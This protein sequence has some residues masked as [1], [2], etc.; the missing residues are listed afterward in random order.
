MTTTTDT[1]GAEFTL[2]GPY[3]TIAAI[4]EANRKAGH[5]F[6]EADS[7]RFFRSKIARGVIIAGRLFITSEQFVPSDGPPDP[8][9]YSVRVAH[10]NGSVATVGEFQA[11]ATL[12]EA[13]RAAKE[14]AR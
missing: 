3:T 8:R 11:Y 5:H 9:R 7:M 2:P 13:H 14:M 4:K 10:D 12:A 6:F 1:Y